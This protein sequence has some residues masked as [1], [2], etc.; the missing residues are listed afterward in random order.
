ME[1]EDFK[2][3]QKTF[4]NNQDPKTC[5]HEW[6]FLITPMK[7]SNLFFEICPKCL[8]SVGTLELFND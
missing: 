4:K 7:D 6:D 1:Y 5:Q 3:M 8:E 2:K